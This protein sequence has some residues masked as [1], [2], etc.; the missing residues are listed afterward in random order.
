MSILRSRPP[1]ILPCLA[2][3]LIAVSVATSALVPAMVAAGSLGGTD[4]SVL[5]RQPQL[6]PAA[7]GN[8]GITGLG[9]A[10]C[11]E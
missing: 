7:L 9:A 2:T 3:F 6:Q 4:G 11:A 1:S 10:G 8:G 5:I